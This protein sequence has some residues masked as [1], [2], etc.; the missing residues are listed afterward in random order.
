MGYKEVMS[1]LE[2][3]GSEQ[4][5]KTYRRHGV[6]GEVY[7]VSYA[8]L[9]RLKKKI[10]VNQELALELW[11]SGNH[12]ARILSTKIADPSL[13]S[14]SLLDA[15]AQD[16]GNYVVTDAFA[17][18]A[19]H[20]ASAQQRVQKWIKS[21]D[22]WIGRAGWMVLA[23]LARR[24]ET[25]PNAYFEPFL[26]IIER[27][28]HT[29]QNRVRDAMNSALIAIGVRHQAL[30]KKALAVAKKIGQVVVD[31]GDTNCKTPDATAYILK[32]ANH[33]RAAQRA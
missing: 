6:T 3:L 16:L 9:E 29:R 15:W 5:R 18:L 27:D 25:L 30:R 14:A 8:H 17:E 26:E 7:G 13:M 11:W 10:K 12:D 1:E 21:K 32:T 22:E 28:I 23:H 2:S 31:H 33:K 20:A 19:S 24:D 4:T